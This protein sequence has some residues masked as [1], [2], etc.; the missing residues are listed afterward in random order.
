M[1]TIL[2][3]FAGTALL[4]QNRWITYERFKELLSCPMWSYFL[5]IVRIGRTYDEA[6]CVGIHLLNLNDE[7]KDHL[8]QKEYDDHTQSLLHL[9]IDMLDKLDRWEDF[10]AALNHV[11]A[12]KRFIFRCH[13]KRLNGEFG[14]LLAKGVV[15]KT[16]HYVYVHE[17]WDLALR[18]EVIE[19]KIQRKK[20]GRKLNNMYHHTRYDLTPKEIE[21]RR[22]WLYDIL[23]ECKKHRDMETT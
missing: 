21:C 2:S 15:S 18:K 9:C 17:F 14:E 7:Y 5:Q 16:E 1:E 13:K 22:K 10:I 11:W 12:D 20:E 19:R 6:L 3:V 8:T 4:K 23:K